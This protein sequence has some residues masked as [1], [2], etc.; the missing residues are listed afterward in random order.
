MNVG[1]VAIY[2]YTQVHTGSIAVTTG[3]CNNENTLHL[4]TS[5]NSSVPQFTKRK[6][7][8][9]NSAQFSDSPSPTDVSCN[10][11]AAKAKSRYEVIFSFRSFT[12]TVYV[13]YVT[14]T[15]TGVAHHFYGYMFVRFIRFLFG[16]NKWEA[17]NVFIHGMT[18]SRYDGM[19][20]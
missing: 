12:Y 11:D 20:Q 4:I 13:S 14:F 7:D 19:A 10:A 3:S 16:F 2:R 5:S 15:S 6:T 18:V 17:G 1:K 8:S 9:S